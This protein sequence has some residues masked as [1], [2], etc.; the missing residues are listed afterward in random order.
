ME[1]IQ[2]V[3]GFATPPDGF[4]GAMKKELDNRGV[5]FISDEVQTGW[6]RTGDHFWGYQAHGITPDILTFAKGV[7]N[8]LALG[9]VVAGAELMNSLPGNSISTFG[10]NPLGAAVA[11]AALQAGGQ[12]LYVHCAEGVHRGPLM[13]YAIALLLGVVALA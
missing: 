13:T 11:R 6:G 2:G 1:P 3:G 8:G 5:L 4:F 9:G 12:V 10:G 7:G